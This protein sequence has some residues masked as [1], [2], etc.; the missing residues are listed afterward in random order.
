[1]FFLQIPL[2][3]YLN[4]QKLQIG[5]TDL[6]ISL[7]DFVADTMHGEVLKPIMKMEFNYPFYVH[8]TPVLYLMTMIMFFVVFFSAPAVE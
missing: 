1:M 2:I 6:F 3:F 5:P 4:Y 7:L 8:L